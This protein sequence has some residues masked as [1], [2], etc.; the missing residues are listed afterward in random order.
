MSPNH[1]SKDIIIKYLL[2][3]K[4]Y[5][6]GILSKNR[7]T[8]K[9][10]NAISREYDIFHQK[11]N[12]DTYI[13]HSFK[14]KLED[15]KLDITYS[16]EDEFKGFFDMFVHYWLLR[17]IFKSHDDARKKHKRTLIDFNGNI[18]HLLM[19]IDNVRLFK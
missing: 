16:N 10:L 15:F 2:F 5:S 14:E 13:D 17:R 3:F 6:E 1:M 18:S 12:N 7:I 11:V 19:E 9:E 8:K 4:D